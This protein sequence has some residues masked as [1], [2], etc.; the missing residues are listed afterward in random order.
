VTFHRDD[1]SLDRGGQGIRFVEC[2]VVCLLLY[3]LTY[4]CLVEST[5]RGVIPLSS[6]S[7]GPSPVYRRA[8]YPAA[9]PFLGRICETIFFPLET[10]DRMFIRRKKWWGP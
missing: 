5:T 8:A 6:V 1:N 3:V 4:V 7:G 2:I 9:G 10:C